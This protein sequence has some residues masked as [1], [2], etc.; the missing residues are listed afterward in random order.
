MLIPYIA[1]YYVLFHVL[2][3]SKYLSLEIDCSGSLVRFFVYLKYAVKF[4]ENPWDFFGG[5]NFGSG[6][7]VGVY[8]NVSVAHS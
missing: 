7:E 5:R 3:G 2:L 6:G 1:Y 4:R 8:R